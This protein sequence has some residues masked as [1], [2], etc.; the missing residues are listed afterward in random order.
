M[1]FIVFLR[2]ILLVK[3]FLRGNNG[4]GKYFFV[5]FKREMKCVILMDSKLWNY[6]INSYCKKIMNYK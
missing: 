1:I 3:I 6:Y 2:F 5:I 4:V